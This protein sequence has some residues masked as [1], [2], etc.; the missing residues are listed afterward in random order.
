MRVEVLAIGDELLD[1]RVA[2]TNTLRL[3]EALGAVGQKIIRRTTVTDDRGVISEEA[4]AI[5]GRDTTL[6]VVSGGLGPTTDDV[7]SEAFADLLE[8]SLERDEEQARVIEE[9]ITSLGRELTPNQLKQADRPEGARVLPNNKGTAPGFEVVYG[10]CRFVAV[11]GVPREF[12]AMIEA[13]VVAPLREAGG[14]TPRV[15][16]RSF[17]LVEAQVDKRLLPIKTRWPAVRVGYRAHF[18]E[19]HV[20]LKAGEDHLEDLNAAEGFCREELGVHLFSDTSGPFAA[21]LVAL[22]KE[23]GETLAIAESC[24]GGLM[25][26]LLTDVSGSSAVFEMGVVAYSN[27]CKELHLEVCSELLASHGA[28]SEAVVLEMARG[29]RRRGGAAVGVAVSG[30]A[31]PTGGTEEKPVGTVWLAVVSDQGEKTRRLSL[32]FERDRNKMISAYAGL[33]LVRRHLIR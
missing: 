20:S 6:C 11:P 30:I 8:V 23:R 33:D 5:A 3:A 9:R 15:L 19:I 22:L 13:A 7:T 28:V 12:D 26:S 10:G 24:T 14:E 17:G 21:S 18:P 4:K 27:R 32:P 25:A 2:D 31:G 1:G 16:L 29:V